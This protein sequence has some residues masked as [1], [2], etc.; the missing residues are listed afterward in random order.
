M[1]HLKE[2]FEKLYNSHYSLIEKIPDINTKYGELSESIEI[3]RENFENIDSTN[4]LDDNLDKMIG[5][6]QTFLNHYKKY[7]ESENLKD[8]SVLFYN[9]VYKFL[10]DLK[11]DEVRGLLSVVEKYKCKQFIIDYDFTSHKTQLLENKTLFI[12]P[13]YDF[14]ES[15]KEAE[16]MEFISNMGPVEKIKA[17]NCFF[18]FQLDVETDFNC[19]VLYELIAEE[20]DNINDFTMK[21]IQLSKNKT[22][23]IAVEHTSTL[24]TIYVSPSEDY[25]QFDDILYILSECNQENKVL[26]KFLKLYQILENFEIRSELVKL[27]R[28]K[29]GRFLSVRNFQLLT[30]RAEKS[31]KKALKKLMSNL[32]SVTYSTN[33]TIKQFVKEEYTDFKNSYLNGMDKER[34]LRQDFKELQIGEISNFD[35]LSNSDKLST[36]VYQL[37]CSIVHN[38]LYE[39]H[40]TDKELREK[41]ELLDYLKYFLIPILE[42]IVYKLISEK[43]NLLWYDVREI[44]LY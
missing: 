44:K 22:T 5:D 17:M 24:P 13:K 21:F 30:E 2:L 34:N 12:F 37:R 10:D 35:E 8:Y 31:E 33:K 27:I 14:Y 15:N 7:Q 38:K 18:E 43:N 19:L 26:S 9:I 11:Q 3:L 39:V 4:L 20:T 23:H 36:I 1:E 28:E 40:L 16:I 25:E 42:K 41:E 29:P 32:Y 6:Y